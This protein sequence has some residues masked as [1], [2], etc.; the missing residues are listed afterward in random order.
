MQTVLEGIV[1]YVLGRGIFS[2]SEKKNNW[3][4]EFNY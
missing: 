2:L 3:S 4:V 1:P